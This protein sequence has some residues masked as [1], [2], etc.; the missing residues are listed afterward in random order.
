MR[1]LKAIILLGFTSPFV[2]I[3]SLLPLLFPF[4]LIV[5]EEVR[6][7]ERGTDILTLDGH[8]TARAIVDQAR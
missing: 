8:G 5:V 3:Y 1:P 7:G 2:I 6:W 4:F